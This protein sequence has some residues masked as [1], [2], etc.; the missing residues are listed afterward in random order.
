MDTALIRKPFR[1]IFKGEPAIDEGGVKKEYFQLL[2][3]ELFDPKFFM[4]MYNS[5]TR[6]YWFNGYTFEEPLKFEL[7]GMLMALAPTNNCL[8]DIPIIT[9]CYKILLDKKPDISDL[10]MWQP[11]VASTFD[12]ILNYSDEKPLEDIL[13]RTFTIDYDVLDSKVTEPL[14]PGGEEIFVTKENRQEFID[15]YIDHLFYK[16]CE[17]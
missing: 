8:L 13:C 1:I 11:E 7:I 2:F 14:K 5:D 12:Y 4:F 16:Q 9:T 6:Q 3:K 10:R 15:L 17:K